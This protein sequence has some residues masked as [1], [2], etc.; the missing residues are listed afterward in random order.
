MICETMKPGSECVFMKKNGCSYNGGNCY[1]IVE[2]CNGCERIEEY[3]QGKFCKIF[4][5][6]R[7]K[8]L[9]NICNM[10]THV[11]REIKTEA[12]KSIDPLKLSKKRAKGK[13]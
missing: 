2:N 7:V 11:K 8:W 13:I 4:A 1:T 12:Q 6:P 5:E 10:A 9:S 3:P